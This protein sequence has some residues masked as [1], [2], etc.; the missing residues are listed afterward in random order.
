[1][2]FVQSLC[3]YAIFALGCPLI[4]SSSY[5]D[6]TIPSWPALEQSLEADKDAPPTFDGM[7]QS[8]LFKQIIL[9]NDEG[10]MREMIGADQYP[11]V[12][13]AGF[14]AIEKS[15]SN[16]ALSEALKLLLDPRDNTPEL[17]LAPEWEIV[18]DKANSHQV[19][20]MVGPM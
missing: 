4:L 16:D 7:M 3:I 18:A 6:V 14:L 9:K 10:L 15:F 1:M 19:V 2:K 8:P 17:L 12:R 20:L 5:G 13:F 11:L